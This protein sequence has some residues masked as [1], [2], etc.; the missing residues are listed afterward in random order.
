MTIRTPENIELSYAL[1]GPGSRA[2]AY[3]LDVLIMGAVCQVLLQVFVFVLA[4]LFSTVGADNNLWVSAIVTLVGFAFYNGYFILLEWLWNGQTPGKWLVRIRVIKQGGYALTFFDTLLRNLLRVIDFLPLFYGVGLASLL[5]T[6]NSQR[7]GDIVAGTLVVYQEPVQTETLLPELPEADP[8]E[9]AIPAAKLGAVPAE[10]I[11]LA[12][13]YLR[14]RNE[15][16]PRPRQELAAEIVEI[17]RKTSG[18]EP[19]RGRSG[20]GFLI[21][22]VRQASP[23]PSWTAPTFEEAEFPY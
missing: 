3:F 11:S 1:A 23:D 2:A 5:M 19:G 4:L 10:V 9:L 17:V 20:E 15:L 12:G 7:V 14:A 6:R 18:L 22:L 21:S 8:A 13:E 16:A